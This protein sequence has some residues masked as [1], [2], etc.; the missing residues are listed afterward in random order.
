LFNRIFN[1]NN[2]WINLKAVERAIEDGSL[3]MEIIKNNKLT[4]K[5]QNVIQLETASGAA[6]KSFNGA[7][8]IN[9]PRSRF[10]PVKTTSDLLLIMSNLFTQKKGILQ[11]NLKRSFPTVPL[12]KLGSAF[13]KVNEFLKRFGSIPD[14]LEL[15]HLT[16]SGD[17]TFGKNVT[18]RVK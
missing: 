4:D 8:G 2:L 12:V 5:G 6:I 7:C 10:L 11:M 1:T 16:V 9:V 17:V 14:C 3:H 15:D 13:V 18:L